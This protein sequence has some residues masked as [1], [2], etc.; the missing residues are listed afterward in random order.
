MFIMPMIVSMHPRTSNK[1]KAF[2]LDNQLGGVKYMEPKGFFD[3]VN[4]EKNAKCV[5]S[6][7]GTVQEECC[8]FRAPT[9]TLKDVTERPETIDCGSNVLAGGAPDKIIELTEFV[10]DSIPNW[11]P[12]PEY[13]TSDVSSTVVRIIL[14]YLLG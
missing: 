10:T 13:L 12:P 14:G 4:V 3:F 6:D 5:L 1:L 2:G 7:S 8:I 9:V 11:N